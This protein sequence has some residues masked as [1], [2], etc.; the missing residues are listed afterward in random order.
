[1]KDL[2]PQAPPL[3]GAVELLRSLRE[4]DIPHG[5]A[6][7]GKRGDLSGPLKALSVPQDAAIVCADDVKDAKPEP[8]LFLTCCASLSVSASSCFAVGD[9]VWDMLA[10]QR[11]GMLSI[12]LL[13]GGIDQQS[14]IQ[15]GAYRVY[16]SPAEL[17]LQLFELGID[18]AQ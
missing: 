18:P 10:A 1:M 15:A 2:L 13:T 14:L 12:G 5:I 4:R 17:H 11:A 7:S 6:T 8:D 16:C 3:P 9:A